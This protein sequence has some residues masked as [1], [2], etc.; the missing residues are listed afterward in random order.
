MPKPPAYTYFKGSMYRIFWHH[1]MLTVKLGRLPLAMLALR[2]LVYGKK[3]KKSAV[4][5]SYNWKI[6]HRGEYKFIKL[7]IYRK[8]FKNVCFGLTSIEFIWKSVKI[9]VVYIMCVL[10]WLWKKVLSLW[11]KYC[12]TT[13]KINYFLDFSTLS[14]NVSQSCMYVVLAARKTIEFSNIWKMYN[15]TLRSRLHSTHTDPS[16]FVRSHNNPE[17]S[18]VYTLRARKYP[19]QRML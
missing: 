10:L 6:P 1:M 12:A 14:C 5:P 8:M 7:A 3:Y 4:L 13:P 15:C 18:F 16:Y 9:E 11:N 17:C 19:H 2:G